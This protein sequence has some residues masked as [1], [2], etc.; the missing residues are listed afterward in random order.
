MPNVNGKPKLP[1]PPAT[2]GKTGRSFWSAVLG[3]Y[4]LVD[5]HDLARL[6]TAAQTLDRLD[7]CAT[8]LAAE[9]L[10]VD[11]RY[12]SK[13]HPAAILE[14]RLKQTFLRTVRELGLDLVDGSLPQPARLPSRWRGK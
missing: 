6:A 1:K 14:D 10:F 5:T 2:L 11:G 3:E 9:G 12:G 8:V 13:P 7:E 4:E